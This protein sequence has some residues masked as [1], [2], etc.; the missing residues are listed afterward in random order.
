MAKAPKHT[1][2][3]QL[4]S[5]LGHQRAV[6]LNGLEKNS[7]EEKSR[8]K[9]GDV[10]V[11]LVQLMRFGEMLERISRLIWL[12]TDKATADKMTAKLY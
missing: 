9:Y 12:K 11:L 3:G 10:L 2:C 1:G 4:K 8:R 6:S 5:I 7:V